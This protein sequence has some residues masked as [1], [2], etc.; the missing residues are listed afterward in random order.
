MQVKKRDGKLKDFSPYRIIEVI[1]RAYKDVYQ[2]NLDE[3]QNE[4]KDVSDKVVIRIGTIAEDDGVV[5]VETIQ[6]IIINELNKINRKVGRAYK[7][8]RITCFKLL[9]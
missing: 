9:R 4:I 8:Y 6:D 2:E 5:E 7:K 3:Y 1:T